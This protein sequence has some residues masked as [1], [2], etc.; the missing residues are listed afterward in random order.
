MREKLAGK[1][2][3]GQGKEVSRSR[4]GWSEQNASYACK[5]LSKKELIAKNK[6]KKNTKK[7]N[8]HPGETYT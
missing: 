8:T 4:M 2:G 5:N 7:Q 6:Y 1:S 3:G